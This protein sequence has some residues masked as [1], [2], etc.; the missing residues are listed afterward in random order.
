MFNGLLPSTFSASTTQV[1]VDLMTAISPVIVLI[2]GVLA[3]AIIIEIILS[4]A[5]K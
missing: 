3:G 4:V 5:R 1:M 2:I